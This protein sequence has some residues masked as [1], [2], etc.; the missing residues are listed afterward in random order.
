M[1]VKFVKKF[2]NKDTGDV[3]D[4]DLMLAAD[5]IKRKIAKKYVEKTKKH[6]AN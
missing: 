2:A 5:L 3:A 4:L 6:A 1:K